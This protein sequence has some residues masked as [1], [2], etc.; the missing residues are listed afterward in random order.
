MAPVQQL[1]ITSPRVAE[2]VET[3]DPVCDSGGLLVRARLTA[4]STGTELRVYRGIPVDEAG[5]FL[6]ERV[7]FELPAPNGY[8]MV[9]TVEAVGAGVDGF[10]VGERVFVPGPHAELV[11]V[12]ADLAVKLPG[13]IDDESAVFLNILEVSHIALRQGNPAPGADLAVLGQGVIGL[14]AIAY[15]QAFGMRTVGID[16][17]APR[18]DVGTAMG[19][20]RVLDPTSPEFAEQMAE[21]CGEAGA[22]VVLEAASGWDAIRTGL[23]IARAD[24]TIVVVARHTDVPRFNPVGHPYLGKR[25]KLVTSYGYPADGQRWDCRSSRALTLELLETGRISVSP[26]ITHRFDWQELPAVYERLDAG[27]ETLV[28]LVIRW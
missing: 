9:G 8:S 16:P 1:Q 10:E 12:A 19:A 23:E 13:A 3:A 18:R 17:S 15:G 4:I 26:L 7:P 21:F 2:F 28:G 6:H 14:S 27:D 24:A 25:L 11:A 5:E 22:D 20:T